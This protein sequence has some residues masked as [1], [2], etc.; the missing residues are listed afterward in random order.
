M[1]PRIPTTKFSIVVDDKVVEY[2]PTD[3]EFGITFSLNQSED[4]VW[5]LEPAMSRDIVDYGQLREARSLIG[6]IVQRMETTVKGT[7]IVL[8]CS[9]Y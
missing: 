7:S 9:R 3:F 6:S 8:I 4:G 2:F 5:Q 1:N